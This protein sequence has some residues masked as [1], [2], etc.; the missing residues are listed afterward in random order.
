MTVKENCYIAV[1]IL[2]RKSVYTICTA[3]LSAKWS[4]FCK[5]GAIVGMAPNVISLSLINISVKNTIQSDIIS[6]KT[7]L[8]SV[9]IF[10]LYIIYLTK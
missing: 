5:I 2:T 6:N 7:F 1:S 4:L 9:V 3:Y 10:L 8:L